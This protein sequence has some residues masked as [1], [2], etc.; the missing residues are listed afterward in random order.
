MLE[1]GESAEEADI[2]EVY[3]ETGAHITVAYFQEVYTR[4]KDDYPNG[5]QAQPIAFVFVCLIRGGN[6]LDRWRGDAAF[7]PGNESSSLCSISSNGI[8]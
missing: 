7:L 1:L 4:Y 6:A 8:R 5:G 3:A 2:R